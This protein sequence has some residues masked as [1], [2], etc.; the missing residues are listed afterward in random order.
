MTKVTASTS[1]GTASTA[2][3][4]CPGRAIHLVKRSDVHGRER[5]GA[6]LFVRLVARCLPSSLDALAPPGD[7]FPAV[8]RDD[9]LLEPPRVAA[10]T[11]HQEASP[12]GQ[13][14]A[15]CLWVKVG[16]KNFFIKNIV[17]KNNT[18]K[19]LL[20]R[21]TTTKPPRPAPLRDGQAPGVAPFRGLFLGCA[22]LRRA[23]V[24]RPSPTPEMASTSIAKLLIRKLFFSVATDVTFC[25]ACT[26]QNNIQS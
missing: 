14:S 19:P 10:R 16:V 22:R 3:V 13:R 9:V 17:I 18:I 7:S 25:Y 6:T 23:A 4:T 2:Q 8:H 1:A 21:C 12:C 5:V 20:W 15:A 26:R 11:G 24:D